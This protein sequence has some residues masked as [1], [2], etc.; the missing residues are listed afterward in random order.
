MSRQV[1]QL[2]EARI[3]GIAATDKRAEM[4]R[5]RRIQGERQFFRQGLCSEDS[6]G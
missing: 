4:V 3:E 5:L 1:I 2:N 6:E